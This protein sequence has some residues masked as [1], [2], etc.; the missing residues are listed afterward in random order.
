MVEAE[1]EMVPEDEEIQELSEE[2]KDNSESEP[3]NR[4]KGVTMV[5]F[6]R[7]RTTESGKGSLKGG[8]STVTGKSSASNKSAISFFPVL[9]TLNKKIKKEK[10][11]KELKNILFSIRN[12]VIQ[13]NSYRI[14]PREL[15]DFARTNMRSKIASLHSFEKSNRESSTRRLE[16]LTAE[17]A[18]LKRTVAEAEAKREHSDTSTRSRPKSRRRRNRTVST[19]RR[20]KLETNIEAEEGMVRRK[21]ITLSEK[22]SPLL[23]TSLN[24]LRNWRDSLM[25]SSLRAKEGLS[26]A[27]STSRDKTGEQESLLQSQTMQ[28][29]LT[30]VNSHQSHHTILTQSSGLGE[31]KKVSQ[32][33]EPK[34]QL[35][36]EGGSGQGE[37]KEEGSAKKEK[38]VHFAEEDI[39][40]E[41]SRPPSS[42]SDSDGEVWF[43]NTDRTTLL[44]TFFED[45][46][47]I[48]EFLVTIYALIKYFNKSH[49]LD[50]IQQVAPEQ[51]ALL[52]PQIC[53]ISDELVNQVSQNRLDNN[54]AESN[55][56]IVIQ[57]DLEDTQIRLGE[58]ERLL[59]RQQKEYTDLEIEA[60]NLLRLYE[61][62]KGELGVMRRIH[63]MMQEELEA[64]GGKI[65]DL[66]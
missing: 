37:A 4:R 29:N 42:D 23:S 50:I 31:G 44:A 60:N 54:M 47:N 33:M 17:L 55:Y 8:V 20:V 64:G 32:S 48:M 6:R 58:T 61:D 28:T 9:N 36:R 51:R 63:E 24:S 38:R 16:G 66:R 41:S 45:E 59:K 57:R 35:P 14:D 46:E 22:R 7:K 1:L 26:G 10:T 62:A 13:R 27:K 34:V 49:F 43:N 25:D 11:S 2:Y 21:G 40:S 56:L 12:D 65:E 3:E 15:K 30:V 5:E 19:K 18:S 52:E 39:L 53:K